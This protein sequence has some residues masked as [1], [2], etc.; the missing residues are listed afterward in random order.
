[1]RSGESTDPEFRSHLQRLERQLRLFQVISFLALGAVALVTYC[2]I[3][4]LLKERATGVLRVRGLVVE[5]DQGR[6]RV[7][8]GAPVPSVG[9][10]KRK[11]AMT[12]LL[13]V[14]E[15]GADR[16][17]L[18]ALTPSVQTRDVTRD[19][20]GAATGLAINDENGNER[21]GFAVESND[22]RIVL[23][24]DYSSGAGE[25]ITLGVIPD[26]GVSIS[27]TIPLLW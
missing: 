4:P 18:G 14:G 8:L 27:I 2:A 16:V 26:Q 11:D 21:G 10:R 25:A 22:D 17:A 7:L 1:M 20:I 9:G 6:E 19:R 3:R 5:D 12:G 23:G 15:N 24:M 13:V